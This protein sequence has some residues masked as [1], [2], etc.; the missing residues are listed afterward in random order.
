[1]S[2]VRTRDQ[3]EWMQEAIYHGLLSCDL[4]A[5]LN[6]VLEKKFRADSSV[7]VDAIWQTPRAGK[8]GAGLI[9]EMPKLNVEQPNSQVNRILGSVVVFEERN[10]NFTPSVG[11]GLTAE[12]WAQLAVEFMRGW[13][14]G[15]SGGLVVE[16]NA[17]VPADDWISPDS[18]IIALRGS[19]SQRATR[20]NYARAAQ[21]V[22]ALAGLE[23]TLTN[24]A[25]TPDADIY[26]TTDGSFPGN[27]DMV[28]DSTA[29]KY[30]GPF[31]VEAGALVQF[32]AVATGCLP[33]HVG[34]QL[35]T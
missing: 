25:A 5:G 29:T 12:Q 35:I 9:V 23:V 28:K 27:P 1:M 11:T 31:T 33:S 3:L 24:G 13:I 7:E 4:F 8:S 15:Q 21:P 10:L 34:A 26:F 22:F 18:G 6:I 20:P 2:S 17:I 30:T 14:I 32:M 16:P 19:V